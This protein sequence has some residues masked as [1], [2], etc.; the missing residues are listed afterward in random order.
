MQAE[1]YI[2]HE[3]R[4]VGIIDELT[5]VHDNLSFKQDLKSAYRYGTGVKIAAKKGLHKNL[6]NYSLSIINKRNSYLN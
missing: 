6:C 3:L 1:D 4:K 5:C 2:L